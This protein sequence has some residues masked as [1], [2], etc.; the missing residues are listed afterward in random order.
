MRERA[1]F[2]SPLVFMGAPASPEAYRISL[3]LVMSG[4]YPTASQ[5][6]SNDRMPW[7]PD[8]AHFVAVLFWSSSTFL[9]RGRDFATTAVRRRT[10][11]H[12][13]LYAQAISSLLRSASSRSTTWARALSPIDFFY[14]SKAGCVPGQIHRAVV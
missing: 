9:G 12:N 3:F 4:S 6:S 13:A 2:L 1:C 8:S 5:Q 14:L 10:A 7:L 11:A